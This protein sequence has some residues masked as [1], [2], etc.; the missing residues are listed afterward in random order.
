[1]ECII[2]I[3][4][5]EVMISVGVVYQ[6]NNHDSLKVG[7]SLTSFITLYYGNSRNF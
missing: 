1:M 4:V 6:I 7:T 2:I 5:V 3:K